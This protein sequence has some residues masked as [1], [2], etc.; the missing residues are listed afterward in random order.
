M[1]S[2]DFSNFYFDSTPWVARATSYLQTAPL[3]RGNPEIA[4][5]DFDS[6]LSAELCHT[7]EDF[8]VLTNRLSTANDIWM[9]G[10]TGY[11]L[12]QRDRAIRDAI[13]EQLGHQRP[14][15]VD[16]QAV[17][18]VVACPVE[19]V[20]SVAENLLTGLGSPRLHH[21]NWIDSTHLQ[22][23]AVS[24]QAI[25]VGL[26]PVHYPHAP[27]VGLYERVTDKS[28]SGAAGFVIQHKLMRRTGWA[29]QGS[30]VAVK[31]IPGHQLQ[32]LNGDIALGRARLLREFR[33]GRLHRSPHLVRTYD[34]FEAKLPDP[35]AGTS[36]V[37]YGITMEFVDGVPLKTM[38]TLSLKDRLRF[39]LGLSNAVETLHSLG[40]VHRDIKP[41][42]ILVRKSDQQLV[43]LDYGIS[44]S[45]ED[46]TV[47]TS[48][49]RLFTLKYAAPEQIL[50]PG[51]N[52]AVDTYALGA[53]IFEILSGKL[54]YE[55][56]HW[57]K[58]VAA[59]EAG[60]LQLV[61]F[62]RTHPD[63]F[64]LVARMTNPLPVERCDMR[65]V[66]DELKRI[67][68]SSD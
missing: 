8:L 30:P 61:G 23:G 46:H 43:L 57:S 25:S 55:E 38:T 14:T 52:P 67:L 10:A 56:L 33:V 45:E 12:Q 5:F 7:A 9:Q 31:L 50:N 44:K 65:F 66:C 6:F 2:K 58:V 53:S 28:G 68:D 64:N 40:V 15:V 18:D 32:K 39:S 41:D 22:V 54:P 36:G 60:P 24:Y 16:L 47:T 3:I 21:A 26:G 48:G 27:L 62:E 35:I 34:L 29:E 49:D 17:A 63:L 13:A 20:R 1:E 37:M 42:N 4:A 11:Y 19:R 59:K 51:D